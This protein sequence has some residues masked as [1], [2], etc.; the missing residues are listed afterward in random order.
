MTKPRYSIWEAINVSL[1]LASRSLEEIRLLGRTP[2]PAGKDGANG[3]DGSD[4]KDGHDGR[5]AFDLD[6]LSFEHDGERTMTIRYERG[7]LSRE[8]RAVFPIPIYRGV[9]QPDQQ[10]E[11]GDI[12]TFGGSMFHA[13]AMTGDKPEEAGGSWTLATKRGRDG[14]NGKDGDRGPEGKSGKVAA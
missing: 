3:K 7:G 2:G 4:G 6:D 1:A 12:V 9:Y 14:R 11:R 5:D 10:Y 8:L 13:N